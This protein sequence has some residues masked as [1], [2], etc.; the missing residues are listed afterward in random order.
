MANFLI[1]VQQIEM[2]IFR[3][4]L[5]RIL[6]YQKK[7]CCF[8]RT[9][10]KH[11]YFSIRPCVLFSFFLSRRASTSTSKRK[12]FRTFRS[13]DVRAYLLCFGTVQLLFLRSTQ[14]GGP[15][16]STSPTGGS[17]FDCGP[18]K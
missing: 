8:F 10:V 4:S 5:N 13:P 1:I 11:R 17:H 15:L 16:R 9:S 6:T 18:N 3:I 7:C 2:S 14:L 12:L